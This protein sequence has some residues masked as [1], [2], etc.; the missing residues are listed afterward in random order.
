VIILPFEK[1]PPFGAGFELEP[2]PGTN[3]V[4]KKGHKE[5]L[6]PAGSEEIQ[7]LGGGDRPVN[8]PTKTKG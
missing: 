8:G 1:R 2:N 6:A 5:I 3:S 4:T 7:A